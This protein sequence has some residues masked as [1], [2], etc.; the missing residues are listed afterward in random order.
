MSRLPGYHEA[1]SKYDAALVLVPQHPAA[2]LGSA[3]ALLASAHIRARAGAYGLAAEQLAGA[4]GR[5]AEAAMT[6]SELQVG[7]K[8]CTC[9]PWPICC[10]NARKLPALWDVAQ[11]VGVYNKW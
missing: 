1:L 4:A 11:L 5:A 3:E 2:L 6:H 8:V 10:S 9:E 7:G